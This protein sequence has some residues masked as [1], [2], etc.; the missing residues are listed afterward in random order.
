MKT[1]ITI[2]RRPIKGCPTF[3]I[4][5]NGKVWNT[6]LNRPMKEHIN[7]AGFSYVVINGRFHT[8]A[9][10]MKAAF[11]NDDALCIRHRDGDRT[12]NKLSN[13]YTYFSGDETL[14]KDGKEKQTFVMETDP[15]TNEVIKFWDSFNEAGNHYNILP[16]TLRDNAIKGRVIKGRKFEQYNN[17]LDGV[18]LFDYSDGNH[19]IQIVNESGNVIGEVDTYKKATA[20]TGDSDKTIRKFLA[21]GETSQKGYR[22]V[23][24]LSTAEEVEAEPKIERV[25]KSRRKKKTES[26][27]TKRYNRK[28]CQ[29]SLDGELI[30]I[31]DNVGEA[32]K[33]IGLSYKHIANAL[34]PNN[35]RTAGGY[36][37]RYGGEPFDYQPKPKKVKEVKENKR[38]KKV[39]QYSEKGELIKVWDSI[40]EAARANNITTAG[41]VN[42]CTGKRPRSGRCIWRYEGDAFDKYGKLTTPK[43]TRTIYQ[44]TPS[45]DGNGYIIVNEWPSVAEA[46]EATGHPRQSLASC[47]EHRGRRYKD[48]YYYSYADYR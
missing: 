18:G 34:N 36:V 15:K 22:Y 8:V 29:Y 32:A 39:Y 1:Q 26:K 25:S 28:V 6:V 47:C 13:L 48:G 27:P 12:N 45:P 2:D 46:S 5:T 21:N 37:W 17:T 38:K 14:N 4:D 20:I 31:F 10:L 44:M 35:K 11:F 9:Y 7:P 23:W 30:H 40:S 24:K 16:H 33:Q 3:E 43:I 41:I 19:I 42:C